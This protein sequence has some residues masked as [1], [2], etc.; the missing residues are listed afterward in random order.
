[1]PSVIEPAKSSR[2]AC[3]TCKQPIQ[4]G[5]LRLGVEAPNTF[6]DSGEPSY[7]W[8]HLACAAKK[9]PAQLR[10]A[11]GTFTGEIPGKDELLKALDESS[12]KAKPTNYPYA[13]LASTGRAKCQECEQPLEKGKLRVAIEREVETGSFMAKGTGYLHARCA[14]A[15]TGD[16]ELLEKIKA[17]SKGLGAAELEELGREI[18]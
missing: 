3:R 14:K 1:M 11:L 10:E 4:K 17:N 13:E 2:A 18:S 8:H 12:A 5:E 7:Q 6:G 16:P 9:K 15:Y